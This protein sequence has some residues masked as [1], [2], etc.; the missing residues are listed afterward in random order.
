MTTL[1]ML[2]VSASINLCQHS[3][4]QSSSPTMQMEETA[5]MSSM[6]DCCNSLNASCDHGS[7]CDGGQAV[8]SLLA[9]AQSSFSDY[10]QS[11]HLE[12]IPDLFLSK[13][14]E[15]LYRPPIAIL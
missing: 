5:D 12:V 9:S 4:P 10:Q 1:P 15:S 8:Y 14:S 6:H 7:S 13:N 2:S 11:S 3:A